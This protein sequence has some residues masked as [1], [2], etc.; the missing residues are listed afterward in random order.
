MKKTL[1]IAV[2]VL[3]FIQCKKNADIKPNPVD[4]YD[5]FIASHQSQVQSFTLNAQ[6][7]NQV[8]G[9]EGTK[10]TFP[11]N[12]IEKLNE[13][14]F[15]GKVTVKLRESLTKDKWIIDGQSTNSFEHL[16]ISA[17]MIQVTASD[18]AGNPLA[19]DPSQ[20]E[21]FEGYTVRAEIP[22][23]DDQQEGYFQLWKQTLDEN[24]SGI[25]TWTPAQYSFIEGSNS[26]FFQLPSF[27]WVNCD[28]DYGDERNKTTVL[29]TPDLS[30]FSG[31]TDVRVILVYRNIKTVIKL[32]PS[33]GIFKSYNNLIPMGSKADV[34]LLG[35]AADGGI[36]FKALRDVEF[37]PNKNIPV[38]PETATAATVDAYLTDVKA[39]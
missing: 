8:Q 28:A 18:S 19:I 31:A 22:K 29:V 32:E 30:A 1:F 16:L 33:N 25:S 27:S 17:G 5:N 24:N 4:S 38:T 13:K 23:H 6:E 35:K 20:R 34:V 3:L 15:E 36:L 10:I 39:D 11:A 9:K 26:Y 14:F 2:T 37:S 7:E 21:L 12:S